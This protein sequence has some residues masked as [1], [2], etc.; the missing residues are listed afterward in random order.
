MKSLAR[1]Y[2]WWPKMD[3]DI[4]EMVKSCSVCQETHMFLVLIDVHSKWIDVYVIQSIRAAKMIKKLRIVFSTHRLPWKIVIDN[5]PTFVSEEFKTFL[6]GNGIK[7]TTTSPYHPSSNGQA[8][9]AVQIVKHSLR[10]EEGENN[11]KKLSKLL[12]KY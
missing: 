9:R 6:K 2:V 12:F 3:C 4:E 11:Q 7:D 8:E 5:A 10:C 1:S